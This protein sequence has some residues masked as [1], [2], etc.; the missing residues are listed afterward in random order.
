[1]SV[2]D[3]AW[4]PYFFS[5]CICRSLDEEQ[6]SFNRHMAEKENE[7]QDCEQRLIEHQVDDFA[8]ILARAHSCA[9]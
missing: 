2:S 1:M 6:E 8:L 3:E 5:A 7:V 4:W 9:Q